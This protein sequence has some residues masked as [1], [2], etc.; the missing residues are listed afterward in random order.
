MDHL[1]GNYKPGY[2]KDNISPCT[3]CGYCDTVELCEHAMCLECCKCSCD[4][5]EILPEYSENNKYCDKCG[6]G[7]VE[8]SKGVITSACS[9]CNHSEFRIEAHPYHRATGAQPATVDE[10][11]IN[12]SNIDGSTQEPINSGKYCGDCGEPWKSCADGSNL[13]CWSCTDLTYRELNPNDQEVI[14][15]TNIVPPSKYDNISYS[16]VNWQPEVQRSEQLIAMV[17]SLESA[18]S[19]SESSKCDT[20]TPETNAVSNAKKTT[21]A[22]EIS[23]VNDEEYEE[24]TQALNRQVARGLESTN[25][26]SDSEPD[27]TPSREVAVS[28]K[29]RTD[30]I[31]L[32]S[33]APVA[34]LIREIYNLRAADGNTLDDAGDISLDGICTIFKFNI[35]N[36]AMLIKLPFMGI[37]IPIQVVCAPCSHKP[38]LDDL[39]VYLKQYIAKET[40]EV[41]AS[42][43]GHAAFKAFY[44]QLIQ[45]AKQ[46]AQFYRQHLV[47]IIPADYFDRLPPQI[48]ELHVN[49]IGPTLYLVPTGLHLQFEYMLNLI[50]TPTTLTATP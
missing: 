1:W 24:I 36:S 42:L 3:Y 47:N 32:R 46:L 38:N 40:G 39:C 44:G 8:P 9:Y 21:P 18:E 27:E 16:R 11:V 30:T 33:I 28:D 49:H 23:I 25:T 4:R 37:Q 14:K 50:T 2:N 45:L 34:F 48:T 43:N 19:D 12:E 31:M 22:P 20:E 13:G 41:V 15:Y 35:G 17:E 26:D 10:S 29:I 5:K 7:W 6:K